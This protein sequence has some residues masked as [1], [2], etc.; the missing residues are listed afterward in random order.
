MPDMIPVGNTIIPPNPNQGMQSLSGILGLQ[1]QQLALKQGQQNLQTGV[2][3]Q[4]SAQANAQQDQQKNAELQA[5]RQL[6]VKGAQSGAYTAPDG[7]LDRAK[8]ADDITKAAPTYGETISNQLLSGANEMIQNKQALQKLNSDQQSQLA[9]GANALAS[10]PDLNHTDVIDYLNN[11]SDRNPALK[12]MAISV[13]GAIPQNA[14]TPDLQ[15]AM[16][17]FAAS[18]GQTN[19]V[20]PQQTSNAAGQIVNRNQL[21]GSLAVAPGGQNANPLVPQSGTNAAGNIINR[22]PITGA[23]SVAPS[24]PSANPSTAQAQ[25][26]QGLAAGVTQRVSQAQAAAN[27]TV[28]A[29][30]ALSRAKSILEQGNVNTGDAFES[31]KK[32]KNLFSSAGIDTEGA[33]D[34]NSLVKNL[35]RYEASRATQAGLGGTDAA[36]ELAHAGSPN[37]AVD[38]GALLGIVNQS[39]GTE[40]AIAAYASKQSKAGTDPATLQKNED[41]FRNIPNLIQG[42]EYGLSK[43]PKEAEG[44]LQKS[45]LSHSDMAKTRQSIKEFESQ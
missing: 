13:A 27:N 44:F 36:R 35:A 41:Q 15:Q 38:N 7:T 37:T 16:G 18:A 19:M 20:A 11:M 28:Q 1:Q 14:S 5:A 12:R 24:T 26:S 33:T 2:F 25:T 9:A 23:V 40:K 21:T 8:L 22:N 34:A 4:Q 10:K 29:Q 17:R 43:N 45:G 30:D 6:T 32:L 42:Y 31:M 3:Q 39:L